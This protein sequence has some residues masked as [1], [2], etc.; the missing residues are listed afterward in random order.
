MNSA[1]GTAFADAADD[2]AHARE[3]GRVDVTLHG[4]GRVHD[5]AQARR[6]REHRGVDARRSPS[7]EEDLGRGKERVGARLV[8][9]RERLGIGDLGD[10]GEAGALVGSEEIGSQR[11]RHREDD[12][13]SVGHR[14]TVAKRLCRSRAPR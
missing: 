4:A 12:D 14:A 11:A 13:R 1:T 8:E 9:A 10:R 3:A 2:D 6:S 5:G 7:G